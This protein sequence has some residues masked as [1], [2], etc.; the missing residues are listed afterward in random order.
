MNSSQDTL[1]NADRTAA[2]YARSLLEASLDPLVTISAE[3]KITDVNDA[4]V[5]AT[6]VARE[7][8]VGT[9]FSD[10]F[11]EPENARAGYQQV[12]SQGFVRDYPLAIRHVS[13]RVT[14]VLYTASVY[15]DD[16]GKVLGVFAAAR[17]VTER[18]LAEEERMK[19]D[20]RLRDQ[21]FYTRSLIESNIDALMTTD[22]SGIIT[23][24]NK[25][26]EALT[27]CTRD[28]L[29]G[30]PFKNYFTNPQRAEAGINAVLR[31]KKVTNYELTARARDG[32]ET[33]VSY[34]ATTFYDR[35]RKLLGVFAAARDVTERKQTEA[36]LSRQV[37]LLDLSSDAIMVRDLKGIISSWNHGAEILYGFSKAEAVGRTSIELLGTQFPR[38]LAELE[39]GLRD[40]G[41]WT[42]ELVHRRKD[43]RLIT[44]STR[45]VLENSA[46]STQAKVLESNT[47]ITV[48]KAAETALLESQQAAEAANRAKSQF[49]ANMSHELRTPL[50]AIIG[51]SEILEDRTFGT[52]NA[53]QSRYV[54]NILTS[55]RHLLQL[56]NDILD[57]SK[58]ETGM[59]E[60]NVEHFAPAR[61]V[62]DVLAIVKALSN[63]KSIV[64]ANECAP[65][66]PA[67][68]ADQGK[69][70]Q[71]LYNLLSNAVKFTPNGGTLT[72]KAEVRG[73]KSDGEQTAEAI[74]QSEIRNP[75]S[76][77]SSPA[78]RVS[79]SDTGIGIKPEDHARIWKEFEQVDSTYAR[80][81]KGTGLGL[82]LTKKLVELHGG[83]IWLE[84][85]GIEGKGSTFVF[86]LPLATKADA[87]ATVLPQPPSAPAPEAPSPHSGPARRL[88]LIVDDNEHARALL[89]DYLTTG[90]Y[91]VAHACTAAEALKL[92]SE[93]R[94]FAITLDILLPDRPGWEVLSDLKASPQTRDIPVVIVSI[95]D[96]K[97]LASSLGAVDFLVKPI[98][99]DELLAII[100]RTGAL[101][102]QAVRTVLI[103]D[104]DPRSVEALAESIRAEGYT[105]LEARSGAEGIELALTSRPDL[106][107]LDLLMPQINGFEVVAH[108]RANPL[109]AEL[110][111]LIYTGKELSAEE[112]TML[113]RQVQGIVSKP[114]REQVLADLAHLAGQRRE[115][116]AT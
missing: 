12:F 69:F 5:Q 34:N 68:R 91:D 25:Q 106:L 21:Q 7:K 105:V 79:V 96:D 71:V 45:W 86:E 93:L 59:L 100:H 44:V 20:Q 81:Q 62:E 31:E 42:G 110:P 116:S 63:K 97:Q 103:V 24:V 73:Q 64:L 101:R 88:V 4:S 36:A 19:L 39:A 2:A 82:S 57:L 52:L 41:S 54:T 38:P 22:P 113:Q 108:L 50:N 11:T 56:I 3:G 94:P 70:K 15:K 78:L 102:Q 60:L 13:G 29:I 35:D 43:G 109:T 95:T 49:L 112:R 111:I 61:A 55:G 87:G 66:L 84:S 75:Q 33:V 83:R 40:A 77:I 23:D 89:D 92:A 30:A 47:D 76:A 14:D 51:F 37:G 17:D 72:V 48:R 46:D 16:Q 6:G 53:K 104:D 67:L 74:A 1:R 9:D 10:Y 58:V 65:D 32:K 98:R 18:K 80:T 99:R 90:G 28:E 115:R 114:A 107:I 8:L 26:M 27:G 85:E